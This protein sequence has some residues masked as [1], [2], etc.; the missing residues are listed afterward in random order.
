[1]PEGDSLARVERALAPVLEG[2]ELLSSDFRVPS[3]ATVDLSG[4][5]IESV[6]AYGK[7]LFMGVAGGDVLHSHLLMEGR[8]A[9]V[10]DGERWPARASQVRAVLRVPGTA[11]LGIDL[12]VL[13]GITHAGRDA[14]VA[15]LGP[16]PIHAWDAARALELLGAQ[17]ERTIGS[18]LLD[19]SV[20]AGL[21][22]IF[23]SE[24]LF[25]AGA[26][27]W[28]TVGSLGEAA[29]ERVIDVAARQL[30]DNAPRPS[31]RTTPVTVRER[32]WVYGRAGRPCPRGHGRVESAPLGDPALQRGRVG[33]QRSNL[34]AVEREVFFC[35][36]CQGV[37]SHP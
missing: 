14:I 6:R 29:L 17:P 34:R 35:R 4:R 25:V 31:R 22:N 37:A 23:R 12:G 16:D 3:L 8:W 20:V 27:P 1:M 36:R 15:R 18:A 32:Y 24:A 9:V 21:G 26:D 28:A 19:Q 10:G 13:E 2:V 7:H 30:Q 5:V 33:G 11:V